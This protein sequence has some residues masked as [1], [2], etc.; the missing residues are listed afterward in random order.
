MPVYA[1]HY[2]LDSSGANDLYEVIISN[3]SIKGDKD[4]I[5]R[6]TWKD[7]RYV[8]ESLQIHYEFVNGVLDK[9]SIRLY[10]LS[11][12][13][14][15]CLD[16]NIPT[17]KSLTK[18]SDCLKAQDKSNL[19]F[20]NVNIETGTLTGQEYKLEQNTNTSCIKE[21][22]C[23][24]LNIS[25]PVYSW[26]PYVPIITSIVQ[27]DFVAIDDVN[28]SACGILDVANENYTLNKS[29]VFTTY[30]ASCIK[31]QTNE[32]IS[33]DMGGYNITG[34][35]EIG[36][37]GILVVSNNIK[38]MN[39]YFY[40]LYTGIDIE[41][42][43]CNII[44]VTSNLAAWSG[45]SMYSDNNILTDVTMLSNYIDIY[46]ISSINNT[47]L[48]TSYISESLDATSQLIRK[49]YMNSF[50]GI[51]P[52]SPLSGVLFNL[53]NNSG[54]SIF[55]DL[56]GVLGTVARQ[57]IT[58]YINNAG[59]KTYYNSYTVTVSKS[60][61][62]G[63][64]RLFNFTA[65]GG[66][67]FANFTMVGDVTAFGVCNSS[68]T[69]VLVNF[70]FKDETTDSFIT[71][72]I[73]SLSVS[74]YTATNLTVRTFIYS[75]AAAN[76]SLQLCADSPGIVIIPSL[77][78]KYSNA[79]YWQRTYTVATSYGP[80]T[81]NKILYLLSTTYGAQVSF[82]VQSQAGGGI[83]GT[84][85]QVQRLVSGSWELINEDL[86]DSSGIVTFILNTDYQHQ[87]TFVKSG[88]QTSVL[89]IRPTQPIYTVYLVPTASSASYTNLLEGIRYNVGPSSG[90]LQSNTTYLFW[91][92]IT[93]SSVNLTNYTLQLEL[94]NGTILNSTTGTNPYGGNLSVTLNTGDYQ[95]IYGKYY[96]NIN[97]TNILIDPSIWSLRN[98]TAGDNSIWKFITN[99]K[100]YNTN[101][102]DNYT[103][104]WFLFFI[105]FM[106][107]AAFTY[108]TGME[109]AQP[110]ITLFL[111]MFIVFVFS[112]AGFFTI[113][114]S[115]NTTMNKYGIL[116]VTIFLSVGYFL[117]RLR[118]T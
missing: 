73:D 83:S 15:T 96:I 68:L 33:L 70:T 91:F 37:K 53:T 105:M 111:V 31:F 49:W 77:V 104:L 61:Y 58:E 36:S 109:L 48:N 21:K 93:S 112:L 6:V 10:S 47:V 113:D 98:I 103:K 106:L 97:G 66:N 67:A 94:V 114:F 40:G 87:I 116:I 26:K 16:T 59:T 28:V 55:S 89:T 27:K 35:G 43:N 4:Y 76:E 17:S 23:L 24:K 30:A 74:W 86:T 5:L 63:Q 46:L 50:V 102:E 9:N 25:Y 80:T 90:F 2:W 14:K 64:S 7:N 57:S 100:N 72:K 65:L 101:I 99:L 42:N 71:A 39:G 54:V 44:N 41:S 78:L 92:N 32:N 82:Q 107:L 51:S 13:D 110:G 85:V 29:L 19:E 118:D 56:T 60:G 52:A 8:D 22:D 108:T 79:N 34:N 75:N 38:I 3:F 95:Q 45:I 84:T 69:N 12:Y 1:T 88:F 117:G 81:T 115:P 20:K 62:F 11:K 18:Y